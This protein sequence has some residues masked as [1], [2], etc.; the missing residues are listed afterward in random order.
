MPFWQGM[1]VSREVR[2]PKHARKQLARE[3][4]DPPATQA[5]MLGSHREVQGRTTM[6]NGRRKSDSCIVLTKSANKLT[7]LVRAEQMEGRRLVKGN[8]DACSRSR[9]LR[10]TRP[11]RGPN[12]HTIG[13]HASRHHLRQEPDALVAL[14]RI[15]GGGV[16]Q[17]ASLLRLSVGLLFS[18]RLIVTSFGHGVIGFVYR[19]SFRH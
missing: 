1:A 19:E 12:L 13:V 15:C 6:M 11:A 8:A 3:P 16:Q 14:V 17:C 10:R 7:L 5:E 18:C 4:G 9:T 2:D